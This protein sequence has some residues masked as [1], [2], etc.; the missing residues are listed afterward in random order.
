MLPQVSL[1][2]TRFEIRSKKNEKTAIL[3]I[4]AHNHENTRFYTQILCQT[5][6]WT[7]NTNFYYFTFKL[8]IFKANAFAPYCFLL[9]SDSKNT[10]MTLFFNLNLTPIEKVAEC[11]L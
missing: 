6:I 3:P 7:K 8:T 10:Q 1:N 5:R 2:K 9:F 4:F 11:N